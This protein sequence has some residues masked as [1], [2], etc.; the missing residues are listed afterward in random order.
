VRLPLFKSLAFQFSHSPLSTC[1]LSSN[2][3]P[4]IVI[5]AA[6]YWTSL[7]Q[8]QLLKCSAWKQ[9]ADSRFLNAVQVR[10]YGRNAKFYDGLP[11]VGGSDLCM[12]EIESMFQMNLR[13]EAQSVHSMIQRDLAKSVPKTPS[14]IARYDKTAVRK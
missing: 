10:L 8:I 3:V 9:A 1:K 14:Q 2:S 5:P 12:A 6:K 13:G 4:A 7:S 11:R